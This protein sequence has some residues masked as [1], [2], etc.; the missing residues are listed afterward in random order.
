MRNADTH[1]TRMPGDERPER[2]TDHAGS[3]YDVPKDMFTLIL[4][5][6]GWKRLLPLGRQCSEW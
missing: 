2:F 3:V 1:A 5:L 6:E 4:Q